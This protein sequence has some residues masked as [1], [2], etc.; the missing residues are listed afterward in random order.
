MFTLLRIPLPPRRALYSSLRLLEKS[1]LE[2]DEM[3]QSRDT[4]GTLYARKTTM[5]PEDARQV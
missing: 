4:A 2:A 3:L 1:L 5:K